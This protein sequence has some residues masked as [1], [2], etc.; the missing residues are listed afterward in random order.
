[1]LRIEYDVD[2]IMGIVAKL[3]TYLYR[4]RQCV[5]F[6]GLL[7]KGPLS[8]IRKHW[9]QAHSVAVI[10]HPVSVT[11]QSK[12]INSLALSRHEIIKDLSTVPLSIIFS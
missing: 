1:M 4:V 9:K 3:P 10:L 12:C 8:V 11:W 6:H 5:Y 2:A 7:S